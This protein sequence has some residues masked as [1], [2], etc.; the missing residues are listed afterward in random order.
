MSCFWKHKNDLGLPCKARNCLTNSVCFMKLV[1]AL[2]VILCGC[3][4]DVKNSVSH[5]IKTLR[6]QYKNMT[7]DFTYLS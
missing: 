4:E 3:S 1:V 6:D 2:L 7:N 5:S